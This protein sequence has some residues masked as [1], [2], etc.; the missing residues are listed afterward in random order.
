MKP[1]VPGNS[2]VTKVM[3]LLSNVVVSG[4]GANVEWAV[5]KNT[6]DVTEN[7]SAF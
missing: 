5:K 2:K 7:K 4:K 3:N 1:G 6:D